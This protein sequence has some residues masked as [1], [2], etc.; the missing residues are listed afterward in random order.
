MHL[1]VPGTLVY[2]SLPTQGSSGILTC[3]PRSQHSVEKN[4]QALTP[5]LVSNPGPSTSLTL[6]SKAGDFSE[7]VSS[8]ATWAR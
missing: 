1:N 3:H 2:S 6:L 4:T 8:S 7:A 5:D